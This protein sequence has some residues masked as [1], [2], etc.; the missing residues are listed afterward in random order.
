MFLAA[1]TSAWAWWDLRI[2]KHF[3]I[4]HYRHLNRREARRMAR[5]QAE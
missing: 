5:G 4:E 2:D 1:L 3:H